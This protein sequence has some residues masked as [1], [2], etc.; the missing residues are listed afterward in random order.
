VIGMLK[1][2]LITETYNDVLA[3]NA[4]Q[5]AIYFSSY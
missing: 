5:N 1:D 2:T 4:K 3:S